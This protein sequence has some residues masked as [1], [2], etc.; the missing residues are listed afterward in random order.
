VARLTALLTILAI[1][2]APATATAQILGAAEADDEFGHALAAGDFNDDSEADLA[3]GVP[4]EDRGS[5]ADAGAVNVLAFRLNQFLH[6]G[7]P[8]RLDDE[9]ALGL[10]SGTYLVRLE[11]GGA[12]RTQRLTLIR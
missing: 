8:L 9:E 4:G 12:A 3:V 6:Q 10:P 1:L 2:G 5:A 11:A 7:A